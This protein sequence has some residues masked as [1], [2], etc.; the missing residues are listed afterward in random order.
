MAD[1]QKKRERTH[2][3]GRAKLAVVRSWMRFK[4]G[5]DGRERVDEIRSCERRELSC[6]WQSSPAIL[7]ASR[8]RIS[9]GAALRRQNQARMPRA[10]DQVWARGWSCCVARQCCGPA[11][12]AMQEDASQRHS[13]A[14][15]G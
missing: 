12:G 5:V 15:L 3:C 4:I 9:A 1:M 7:S 11:R 13:Q 14:L 10:D 6:G 8:R 2:A